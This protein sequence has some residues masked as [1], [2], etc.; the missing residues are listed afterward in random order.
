MT[1]TFAEIKNILLLNS[2]EEARIAHKK[3]IPGNEIIYGVRTPV[4]NQLAKQYKSG[5]FELIMEIW[6]GGSL[7]EKI[8]AAKMLGQIAKTNPEKSFALVRLFAK[9]I[10]NWA[11]CDTIGMQ[12]LK[13]LNKTHQK[14]IFE[15]AVKFN[16]SKDFWQRRLS[17][18]LVEWYTRFAKLHPEIKKLIRNLE[19]DKEYYVKK[20]II[21][22]NKNFAKGR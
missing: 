11:V 13:Q 21:W 2:S 20:A 5:G 17:L 7:E 10:G 1:A 18:V 15:I 16:K 3:F 14:E 19:N 12:G 4:L 8:L 6:E 22:I 9:N